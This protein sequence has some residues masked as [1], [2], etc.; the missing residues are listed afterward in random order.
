MRARISGNL[1][2]LGTGGG[3]RLLE[4][5]EWPVVCMVVSLTAES[6]VSMSCGRVGPDFIPLVS[7]ADLFFQEDAKLCTSTFYE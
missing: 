4:L 6:F 2:G 5:L 3:K 7:H 1:Y